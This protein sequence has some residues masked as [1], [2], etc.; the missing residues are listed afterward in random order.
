MSHIRPQNIRFSVCIGFFL[1][2]MAMCLA[3][4][5]AVAQ[6]TTYAE[7][8]PTNTNSYGGIPMTQP[9]SQPV[10]PQ[11][12]APQQYVPQQPAVPTM[13]VP[14]LSQPPA[15]EP[16]GQGNGT[17]LL[18][19]SNPVGNAY[20]APGQSGGVTPAFQ[21]PDVQDTLT[22]QGLKVK[23]REIPDDRRVAD[24]RYIDAC[25]E[26]RDNKNTDAWLL[27]MPPYTG[28]LTN[29]TAGK[30]EEES[31]VLQASFM[32]RPVK[33]DDYEYDWEKEGT[34]LFDSSL[35]DL[36]KL[37]DHAKR[38]VGLGPDEAKARK[39][40]ENALLLMKEGEHIKAA[41]EFEWAAYFAPETAL[42]EDARYHAAECYYREKRYKEAAEQYIKLLTNF[43]S[44]PYK[45]EIINNLYGIA[46]IWIDQVTKDKV[47]YVNVTDK[48]RPSFDTFGHAERALKA[49]FIN[50]PSDPMADDCV[51]AL[52]LAYMRCGTVQG[53][54]SYE[55]AAEYFK[56][57][58]DCYPNSDH[59]VDAMQQEAIC[60][61]RASLGAD[62]SGRHI[63]EAR[64][65]A[66]QLQTQ[67]RLDTTKQG[68]V[69][70]IR[71]GLT[72]DK[73]QQIWEVA[74][75]Y[76]S[77]KDYGAARLQYRQLIDDYPA[78]KY[79]EQSRKR[80]EEIRDLPDELPSDWERIK[81]AFRFGRK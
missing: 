66:E 8:S 79:A 50:C 62:Y 55:H 20:A 13:S 69:V 35:L 74:R 52:A 60:R 17:P 14:S 47:G 27:D 40:M 68:E 41:K 45:N 25:T 18:A 61:R 38:W 22:A 48:S 26:I 28:P 16:A 71:N 5:S 75:F 3:P 46:K 2:V 37:G 53:D 7:T 23:K 63:D 77:R 34:H 1:A 29:R 6:Y 33:Q 58:R 80:F 72:D 30:G 49:I 15:P 32:N 9:Q 42:E 24:Q 51:Y 36:T 59:V 64:V 76:D 56:Q 11:Q 21:S 10:V 12:Y 78:T 70:G 19:F 81:S 39:R 67:Y 54:A 44:S 43:Q 57:L 65:I 4:L 31:L 73:A